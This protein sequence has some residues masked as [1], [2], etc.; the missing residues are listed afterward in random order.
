VTVA[1]KVAAESEYQRAAAI[2]VARK[3]GKD[4]DRIYGVDWYRRDGETSDAGTYFEGEYGLEY[5][6]NG[7]WKR[8][9]WSIGSPTPG[10]F[11]E[12]CVAIMQEVK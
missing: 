1:E 10:R 4:P 3:V 5:C 12:E 9:D 7:S 11:L 8:Y 6:D 2:W